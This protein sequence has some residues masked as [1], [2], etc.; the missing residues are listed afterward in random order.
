MKQITTLALIMILGFSAQLG[1]LE[2]EGERNISGKGAYKCH[3]KVV[4]NENGE[5][6]L[7]GSV[8]LTDREERDFT[9]EDKGIVIIGPFP[10]RTFEKLFLGKDIDLNLNDR[11]V[12][13]VYGLYSKN[14]WFTDARN[15]AI[16]ANRNN[17][18][19]SNIADYSQFA[20]RLENGKFDQL[21][22]WQYQNGTGPLGLKQVLNAYCINFQI[23][24]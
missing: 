6:F 22:L 12:G 1:A 23:V 15:V 16:W 10:A 2:F 21:A 17:A 9:F 7:D 24:Q 13:G 4:T 11:D 3:F 19:T 8:D 20:L 5:E 18:R 14:M